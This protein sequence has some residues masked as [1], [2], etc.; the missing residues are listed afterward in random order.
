MENRGT[1]LSTQ[2]LS[3]DNANLTMIPSR[4]YLVETYTKVRWPWILLPLVGI[5]LSPL[6]LAIAIVGTRHQPLLKASE[7][8]LHVH[9]LEGWSKNWS[10]PGKEISK[11]LDRLANG[12]ITRWEENGEGEMKRVRAD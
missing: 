9:G 3:A 1:T 4:A 2:I 11:K 7:T 6:L 10:I 8:A 12:M 5:V